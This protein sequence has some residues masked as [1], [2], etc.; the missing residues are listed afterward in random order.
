MKLIVL[1]GTIVSI[2]GCT[3]DSQTYGPDGRVSHSITCKGAL[4]SMAS[5][6][7]QAGKICGA[8]GYDVIGSANETGFVATN[9]FAGSTNNRS[10]LVS[11]KK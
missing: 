10:L 5:C 6:F 2:A 11:C 7:D 8:A 1:V 4:L 3:T 9:S